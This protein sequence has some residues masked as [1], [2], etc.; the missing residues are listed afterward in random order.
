[1]KKKNNQM[2]EMPLKLFEDSDFYFDDY[3][4]ILPGEVEKVE[5]ING[6]KICF[7]GV[8][9]AEKI[10]L[11]NQNWFAVADFVD[12]LYKGNPAAI[13]NSSFKNG[14]SYT[15]FAVCPEVSY[16]FVSWLSET[17]ELE[18]EVIVDPNAD[19]QVFP[20]ELNGREFRSFVNFTDQPF[21]LDVANIKCSAIELV[22]GKLDDEL[23]M[24]LDRQSLVVGQ[25]MSK[26]SI[27]PWMVGFFE[28]IK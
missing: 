6:R 3:G 10:K 18:N 5:S 14:G 21:E 8:M 26:L 17:L 24:S 12:G 23:A 15:H 11:V 25:K 9:W 7:D 19:V 20:L 16:E 22:S 27:K 4:A 1:M 13:Q 28:L 2:S